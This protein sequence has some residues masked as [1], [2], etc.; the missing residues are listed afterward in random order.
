M[1]TISL[2]RGNPESQG[3]CLSRARQRELRFALRFPIALCLALAATGIA[4]ESAPMLFALAPI[5]A[6]AGLTRRHPFDLLW[7]HAVR[8]AAGGPELPPNPPPRRHAFKL[9]TVWLLATASLFAAGATV[10][11]LV[12]GGLLVVA[13]SSAA[14]LNFCI[15]SEALARWARR[16]REAVRARPLPD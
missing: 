14:T 10:A 11:G 13:C 16:Q 12:L 5:G 1:T 2:P 8:R 3:Y 7:N 15:P 6:I 4:L 9:A